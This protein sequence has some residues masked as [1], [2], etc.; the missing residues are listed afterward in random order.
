MGLVLVCKMCHWT[1]CASSYKLWEVK[2]VTYQL[3]KYRSSCVELVLLAFCSQ[4]RMKR[5]KWHAMV[6]WTRRHK[7]NQMVEGTV[8]TVGRTWMAVQW[9]RYQSKQYCGVGIWLMFTSAGTCLRSVLA[10]HTGVLVQ[11]QHEQHLQQW[12]PPLAS[13]ARLVS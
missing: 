5:K 8:L 2:A 1:K 6:Y 13:D 12:F 7:V 9:R 11:L 3:S 10:Q 4:R